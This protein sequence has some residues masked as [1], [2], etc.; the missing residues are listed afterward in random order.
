M[1]A[2]RKRPNYSRWLSV[3]LCVCIIL[4]DLNGFTLAAQIDGQ[5]GLCEHH[6]AHS[7]DCGF[8]EAVEGRPCAH[9]HSEEYGCTEGPLPASC[10]LGGDNASRGFGGDNSACGAG[11]VPGAV[12]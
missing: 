12:R 9:V 8:V 2:V 6:P 7:A 4:P 3:L 5:D 10:G 11:G 1:R